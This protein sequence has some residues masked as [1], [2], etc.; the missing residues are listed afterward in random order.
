M[1]CLNE[2]RQEHIL[3]CDKIVREI[4]EAQ[5]VT[6]SNIFSNNRRLMKDTLKVIKKA[7]QYREKMTNND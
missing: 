6:Y 7:L 5:N 2:D 3:I 4:P 1:S